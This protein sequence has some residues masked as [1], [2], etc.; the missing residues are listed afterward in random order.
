M[1]Y[2]FFGRR[3]IFT[4][5]LLRSSSVV[6]AFCERFEEYGILG[7]NVVFAETANRHME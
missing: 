3:R 4:V 7:C 5:P 6:H 1:G 2:I